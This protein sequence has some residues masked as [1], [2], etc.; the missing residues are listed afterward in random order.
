MIYKCSNCGRQTELK[1]VTFTT[2]K[3]L[4][5]CY[6]TVCTTCCWPYYSEIQWYLNMHV[7]GAQLGLTEQQRR[8][9]LAERILP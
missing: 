7:R 3:Q 9:A 4:S 6:Y 2:S 8:R 5:T 1:R